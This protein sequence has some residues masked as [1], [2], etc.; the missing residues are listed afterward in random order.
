MKIRMLVVSALAGLAVSGVFASAA[1]AEETQGPTHGFLLCERMDPAV[2]ANL[3]DPSRTE[4][5]TQEVWDAYVLQ[6]CATFEVPASEA[7]AAG[8]F[9]DACLQPYMP[10]FSKAE[11]EGC[12]AA[13][14][15]QSKA[16]TVRSGGIGAVRHGKAKRRHHKPKRHTHAEIA[17]ARALGA[18]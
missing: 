11:A 16:G 7:D 4:Q 12:I 18:R 10:S 6:S 5:Q 15:S 17:L 8:R 2:E 13:W 9:I 1:S 14:N 3:A